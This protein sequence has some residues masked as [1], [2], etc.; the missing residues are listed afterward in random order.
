MVA[1]EH[2]KLERMV[3]GAPSSLMLYPM[4]SAS[5][6]RSLIVTK[7]KAVTLHTNL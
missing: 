2:K 7:I 6:M 3:A 1:C 4:S 5:G